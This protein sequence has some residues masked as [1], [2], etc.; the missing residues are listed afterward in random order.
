M[1]ETGF[2]A[3]ITQYAGALR[4][5]ARA[6]GAGSGEEEDLHQEILCQLWRSLPSRRGDSAPGTWLY[7]VALNTALS[8]RRRQSRRGRVELP[9][10][11][12]AG[13][14]PASAGDPAD[15]TAILHEFLGTLGP[16]DRPALILY[17]DGLDYAEIGEVLGLTPGAVGVRLH[18]IKQAYNARYLEG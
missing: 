11:A 5:I 10:A 6:Y 2:T 1:D 13:H 8:H 18:R 4:R 14:Q 16:V 7:R 9:D 12:G 17:M 3:L 15:V